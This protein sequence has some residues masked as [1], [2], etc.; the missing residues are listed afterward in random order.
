M[1]GSIFMRA[2][3][4]F[5]LFVVGSSAVAGCAVASGNTSGGDARFDAAAPPGP[6]TETPDAGEA[7]A[8]SGTTFTDIYRDLL[9][10]NGGGSCAGNGSCHG[11][12]G[13]PGAAVGF[14]CGT[15]KAQCRATLLSSGFVT[16][17]E[18]D[19]TKTYLYSQ[20]RKRNADG[21]TIGRMPKAPFTYAFSP[22]SVDRI[23]KWVAAGALD[24]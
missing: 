4:L 16:A 1:V 10:P 20:I 24:D 11:A 17:G 22:A 19:F 12:A 15:D 13:Q 5:G 14:I 8:G 2:R 23:A 18:K 6:V 3:L 7:D 9:G 21:T